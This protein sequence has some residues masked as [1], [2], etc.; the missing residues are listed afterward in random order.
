[1][2]SHWLTRWLTLGANI[3]VLIGIVLVIVELT[4]NREMMRAQTRHDMAIGIV[5]GSV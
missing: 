4:Q 2:D 1:M 3:A 5:D